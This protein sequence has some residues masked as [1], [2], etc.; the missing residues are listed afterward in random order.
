MKRTVA[1]AVMAAM[2]MLGCATPTPLPQKPGLTP[3]AISDFNFTPSRVKW[4]DTVGYIFS[5]RGANGGVK[6]VVLEVELFFGGGRFERGEVQRMPTWRLE[7]STWEPTS[8]EIAP[9]LNKTE[10]RFEK[11]SLQTLS[12]PRGGWSDRMTFVYYLWIVDAEGL[13]SN[14][15]SAE[16]V[17]SSR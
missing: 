10:G 8:Q 4:G 2:L 1:L 15:L 5:Y 11:R 12:A 6:E 7:R 16:L 17:V 13:K 9:L 3:P 14:I